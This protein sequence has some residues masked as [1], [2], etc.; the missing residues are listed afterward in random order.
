MRRLVF[1][2]MSSAMF[3]A[4][5]FGFLANSSSGGVQSVSAS[6]TATSAVRVEALIDGK[7][8]LE[9]RLNTVRWHHFDYAAPGRIGGLNVPTVING[10]EWYPAW[11]GATYNCN[12]CWSDVFVGVTPSVPWGDRT[13]SLTRIRGRSDPQIMQYPMPSNDFTL[14]VEFDDNLA[15]G[16]DSVIVEIAYTEP[17]VNY[18]YESEL[19]HP[20]DGQGQCPYPSCEKL[21][22]TTR[23]CHC[24][25]SGWRRIHPFTGRIYSQERKTWQWCCTTR[26]LGL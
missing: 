26:V 23:S 20:N 5:V 18:P 9:L 25:F 17:V 15:P 19:R 3:I 4:F 22:T 16:A 13:I 14:V 12:G 6:V 7:S 2:L 21:Q 10:A 11:E 1:S 8:Q 24:W